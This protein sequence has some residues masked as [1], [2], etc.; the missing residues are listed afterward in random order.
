LRILQNDTKRVIIKKDHVF[1]SALQL[2]ILN[3]H[4]LH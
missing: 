4:N 3:D 1:V 2:V